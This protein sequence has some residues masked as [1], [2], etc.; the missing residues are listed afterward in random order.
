MHDMTLIVFAGFSGMLAGWIT[1]GLLW[2]RYRTKVQAEL[3]KLRSAA[4]MISTK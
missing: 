2:Y 4:H 1:L 3:E